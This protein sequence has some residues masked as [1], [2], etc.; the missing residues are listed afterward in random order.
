MPFTEDPGNFSD[1]KERGEI[2]TNDSTDD[3]SRR[4]AIE[5]RW[6]S[7][8]H[9]RCGMFV[10]IYIMNYLDRNNISIVRL[11]GVQTDSNSKVA[12]PD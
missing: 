2:V 5:R 10:L 4:P 1:I 11:R 12:D 8:L 3:P 7:K 9:R 6:K